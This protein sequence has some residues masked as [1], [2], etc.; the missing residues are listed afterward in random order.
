MGF[1][2]KLIV[3]I[4]CLFSFCSVVFYFLGFS[5]TFPFS[6]S[7]D[8]YVPEHRLHAIRLATFTTFFYFGFRYIFFGTTKLY[9]IQYMGIFL[10]NLGVVGGLCFY[11]N[12]VQFSEYYLVPLYIILS[13]I[14]YNSAKPKYR[15][16]FK[17]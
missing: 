11:V 16:Y 13:I 10:F 15:S 9:P 14:L 5:I 1:L 12:N 8:L 6:I 2:S 3:I 4:L 17:K 7:D